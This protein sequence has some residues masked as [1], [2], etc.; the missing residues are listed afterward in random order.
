MVGTTVWSVLAERWLSWNTRKVAADTK[1]AHRF[2][3]HIIV[4]PTSE[5]LNES[6]HQR[7][8]LV[9]AVLRSSALLGNVVQCS[10]VE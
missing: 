2:G 3:L 7:S 5:I 10:G 8:D 1:C 9:G 4:T 6:D